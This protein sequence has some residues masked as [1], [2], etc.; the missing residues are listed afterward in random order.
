MGHAADFLARGG[1][2][3]GKGL[4]FSGVL[5]LACDEELGVGIGHERW[6]V[7]QGGE[8]IKKTTIRLR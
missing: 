8:K 1:V 2:E 7:S 5:P 6:L 4:A 3:H